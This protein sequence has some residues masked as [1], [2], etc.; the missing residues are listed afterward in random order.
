MTTFKKIFNKKG[1]AT[2]AR[3][4]LM[5]FAVLFGWIPLAFGQD[6]T[7]SNTATT[8]K[9]DT[10]Q[11]AAKETAEKEALH[12]SLD[13]FKINDEVKLMAKV[14]HKVKGKFQ[15]IPGIEVDFYKKEITAG[16]LLGKDTSDLD[17]EA[18]W[19]FT[20]SQLSDT[21]ATNI[22]FAAVRNH[23]FYE[24]ADET[25]TVSPSIMKMQ[26]EAGDSVRTVK[27]FLGY[28]DE[29]GKTVPVADA[30]CQL[31]VKRL[32][33]LLP[34]GDAA[35]TDAEG[36]VTFEFP[37]DIKGDESGNVTVVT[38]IEEHEIVGNAEVSQLI[39][40]GIPTKQEDFYLRRELWSAR[41]NSPITL[42][43]IVNAILLG[44]WGAIAY[45]FLEIIRINKIGKVR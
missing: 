40:W 45:I 15:P 38:K 12:I 27:V 8:A 29:A 4:I 13:A 34:L 23:K 43:I 6:T 19:F 20:A 37:A 36:N 2:P 7:T 11:S 18:A 42:V 1:C 14:S 31:Y 33:G 9:A 16:N 26:L 44:V 24:D 10:T 3:H 25:V 32:F 30:S 41:A 28:P 17:G 21:T 39:N 5:A 35:T 22:Y